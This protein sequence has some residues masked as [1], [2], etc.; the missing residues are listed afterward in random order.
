[1]HR[2]SFWPLAPLVQLHQELRVWA[3]GKVNLETLAALI[4]RYES[5]RKTRYAAV[6]A[7]LQQRLKW[8]ENPQIQAL[9]N[10][11]DQHYRGANM[12]LAMSNDLFN[13]MLPQ[14]AAHRHAGPR[15]DCRSKS[16]W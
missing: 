3:A 7:Q 9:A 1:M 5:G 8:S 6:I 2:S 15:S 14:A 16:S 13:R 11:L 12:R 10:R 4:E